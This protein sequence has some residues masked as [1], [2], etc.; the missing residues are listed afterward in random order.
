M[1]QLQ[2]LESLGEESVAKTRIAQILRHRIRDGTLRHG[3]SLPSERELSK[4]LEV[5]RTVVRHALALLGSEGLVVRQ[6]V[7]NRTVSYETPDERSAWVRRSIVILTPPISS[8][9]AGDS[10]ARWLRYMT[11]GSIEHLRCQNIHTISLRSDAIDLADA[12]RMATC[13]PMG[14]LVPELSGGDFDTAPLA[15]AFRDAGVPVVCYGGHESLARFDRVASDHSQGS[16]AVTKDL[17]ARGRRR[18]VQFWPK[19][20]SQYWYAARQVGYARAMTEAGLSPLPP[21]EFPY[22]AAPTEDREVFEYS[23]KQVTGFMME[24]MTPSDR[25][26]ALLM[27]TDREVCY[28]AAALRRFGLEPNRDVLIAG[29]DNYWEHCEERRFEPT[30]PVATLDKQN[31]QMGRTMVDLLMERIDGSAGPEPVVRVVP[32]KLITQDAF[33]ERLPSRSESSEP[34]D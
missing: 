27:G 24:H 8:A 25:P 20:W 7:R 15:E 19:P 23:V 4:Q 18:I 31:E 3:Q 9:R 34:S 5:G 1:P 21:M 14:L 32:P 6:G 12:R 26:D 30:P 16:Y 11:L 2:S 10:S 33:S 28:A 17:L 22:V 29:Y 13:R